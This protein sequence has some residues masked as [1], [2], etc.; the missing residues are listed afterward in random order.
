MDL[1][2]PEDLSTLTDQQLSDLFRAA[3]SEERRVS[4]RRKNVHDRLDFTRGG[5][6]PP[7]LVEKLT[8]DEEQI[9]AERRRLHHLLDLL[10]AERIRRR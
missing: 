6:G 3:Q 1:E 10:S 9:S 4:H 5:G 7:D 8:A 2:L